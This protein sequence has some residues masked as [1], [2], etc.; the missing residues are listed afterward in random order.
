MRRVFALD[1]LHHAAFRAAVGAPPLDARE[2]VIAMHRVRQMV[3]PDK[4][5]A[6]HARN[7]FVRHNEAVS[8][9]VRDNASGNQIRIVAS[10]GRQLRLA[11]HSLPCSVAAALPALC[12]RAYRLLRFRETELAAA[13]FL[14]I[15]EAFQVLDNSRQEPPAVVLEL[16]AVRDLP[17]AFRTRSRREI[18]DHLRFGDV[19]WFGSLSG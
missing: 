19:I 9:P 4:K 7:W 14:D 15:A 10:P 3:A 2:N 16:H 17:D 12:S 1:H 6:F 8:I 13:N 11:P 18:R 5:I